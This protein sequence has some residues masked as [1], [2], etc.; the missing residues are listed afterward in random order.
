MKTFLKAVAMAAV[1]S[2]QDPTKVFDSDAI[3]NESSGQNVRVTTNVATTI[4]GSESD[5]IFWQVYAQTRYYEDTGVEK[6][7]LQHKLAAEIREDDL[8]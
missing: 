3:N 7:R 1:C 4:L 5:A 6:V 2:A 8:V